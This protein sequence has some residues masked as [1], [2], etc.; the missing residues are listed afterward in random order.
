MLAKSLIVSLVLVSATAFAADSAAKA[1]RQANRQNANSVCQAQVA[2]TACQGKE[3]GKGLLK[4]M[5]E[6]KIK[7]SSECKTA[8][9]TLRADRKS[10]RASRGAAP[11]TT[12]K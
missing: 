9:Q 6:N 5:K 11:Q 1:Q 7:P 8:L 12:N 10:M 3:V 4:C 2:N